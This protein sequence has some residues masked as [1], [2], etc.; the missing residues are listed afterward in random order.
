MDLSKF[1]E[2]VKEA[3]PGAFLVVIMYHLFP[4]CLQNTAVLLGR[5]SIGVIMFLIS[6]EVTKHAR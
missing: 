3:V 4:E 5:L 1:N 2:V 6:W